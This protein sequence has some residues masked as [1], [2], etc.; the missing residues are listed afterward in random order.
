MSHTLYLDD[1]G[2]L[3]CNLSKLIEVFE[4]YRLSDVDVGDIIVE[5]YDIVSDWEK[6]AFELSI[7]KNT[8]KKKPKHREY[9]EEIRQLKKEYRRV[10]A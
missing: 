9:A 8:I 1:M 2:S 6:T 5:V 10:E 7:P 3:S 4:Y